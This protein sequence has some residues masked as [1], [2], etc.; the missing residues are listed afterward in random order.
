VKAR[1]GDDVCPCCEEE[2]E[3]EHHCPGCDLDVCGE[4]FDS[5]HCIACGSD[6]PGEVE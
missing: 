1:V 2:A 4:C 5:E 3:R 6:E